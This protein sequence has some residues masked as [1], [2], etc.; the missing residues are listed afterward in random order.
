MKEVFVW[1]RVC[2]VPRSIYFK[3]SR[4]VDV[5]VDFLSPNKNSWNL[6]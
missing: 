2:G 5:D 4:L 3:G 6:S 1:M